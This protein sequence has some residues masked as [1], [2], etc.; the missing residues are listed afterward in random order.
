MLGGYPCLSISA[1]ITTYFSFISLLLAPQTINQTGQELCFIY[2]CSAF[3]NYS[4]IDYS[5][6]SIFPH[7][8]SD[9][10]KAE[11]PNFVSSLLQQYTKPDSSLGCQ[12]IFPGPGP[13]AP[14]TTRL[15]SKETIHRC[16]HRT[17]LL[18]NCSMGQKSV[19]SFS[20]HAIPKRM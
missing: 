8:C 5:G 3:L 10:N 18:Q 20:I 6:P 11:N 7:L 15:P 17:V 12:Y 1:I 2:T 19:S 9:T 16:K 14:N 4:K 13:V